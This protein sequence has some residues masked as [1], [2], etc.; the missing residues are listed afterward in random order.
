MSSGNVYNNSPM[1]EENQGQISEEL[2]KKAQ[3]NDPEALSEIYRLFFKKIFRFVFFRVSHKETSEDLS[4]EVFIKAFAKLGSI[5]HHSAFEGWLYQ[6]ARNSVIDY[7]RQKKTTVALEDVENTL[8]YE[9]N[10]I[11]VVNLDL[12]QKQLVANLKLLGAEQQLVIKLKFFENLDNS[13]IAA[14]LKKN[15]GAVRVIQHRAL[16]KLQELIRN[17]N[18]E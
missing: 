12:R 15:E 10:V 13:E 9:S 18:N 14:L 6:I 1:D 4:E 7:Y 3:N 16:A 5:R 11:D 2:L 8:E 17:Q